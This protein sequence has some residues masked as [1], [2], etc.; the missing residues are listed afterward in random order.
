[1]GLDM[2]LS[3]SVHV[4][5]YPHDE[6]GTKMAKAIMD[7]LGITDQVR[8]G[9]GSLNIELPQGYWRKANAIHKWFVDNVQGGEDNCESHY[10]GNEKLQELQAACEEVLAAR[11]TL[12]AKQKAESILPPESGFCFGPTDIDEY[13]YDDLERTIEICKHALDPQNAVGKYDG[14]EYHSSW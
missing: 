11:N 1:M 3:R 2:Y 8:Y 14:F 4:A 13:Y 7:A 10:V 12:E 9:N 6:D 5:N